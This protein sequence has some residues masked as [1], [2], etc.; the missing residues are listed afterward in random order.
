MPFRFPLFFIFL[1]FANAFADDTLKPIAPKPTLTK[2]YLSGDLS[3]INYHLGVLSEIERLQIRIDSVIATEWGS[4]A[5]ALWSAGWSPKQIGELVKSWDSLPPEP[6]KQKSA[7]WRKEWYVKHKE[8][9]SPVFEEIKE[10][11]R[12][13][14]ELFNLQVEESYWRSEIGLRI[15]F[16]E[17]SSTNSFPFPPLGD[18][19][20]EQG[21][22][23]I[24]S[25]PVALRD[26]GG[27]AE[28]RYQQKLHNSDSSLI[29][30]RPHSKPHP[31]SLFKA[32][33]QAVQ[34]KR[35]VL[36]Q[37]VQFSDAELYRESPV[38]A[39]R[40][41]YYPVFDS[42]PAEFQGHL[43][44]FWNKKDT[45]SLAVKNF[46]ANLQK[47]GFYQ[48][49]KLTLDTGALLQINT[50][51]SPILSL[52]LQ[53]IGGTLFGANISSSTNLRFVNQFGY[54][55]SFNAFYG[56][57]IRGG[58]IVS[59]FE[60]F[61][62]DDG[63]FFMEFKTLELEPINYFQKRIEREAR[64]LKENTGFGLDV[65]VKK[66]LGKALLTVATQIDR[67]E[68]TS[69]ASG[70]ASSTSICDVLLFPIEGFD[71]E[72]LEIE[73]PEPSYTYRAIT[74]SS[75]FPYAKWLWQ[76]E[77]YDRWFA[78][79]GF[80]AELMGGFKAVSVHSLEQSAPL[81]F[82][83]GGKIS[84]THPFSKYI[85]IM[86]GTE[87]GVNFRRTKMGDLV[88]PDELYG[89]LYGRSHP[90]PALDNRYRFA[91]GM[92]QSEEQWQTPANA[93][94]RYGLLLTGLSLHLNGNGL[95]LAAGYAKDGEPNPW[96]WDLGK[97]RFFAEPKIRIK[98]SAFDFIAGQS[99]SYFP[100]YF[101]EEG[102]EDV[103]RRFFLEFRG[104]F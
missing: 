80:M 46:L 65:G 78:T 25:T 100:D 31:D 6:A 47:D 45:G 38:P 27:T 43:E 56:Q 3:S 70:I 66:P 81:Y 24:L 91:M 72:D 75:M 48:N 49:V 73:E 22:R 93:S 82:S 40:F 64:I 20:E 54:N 28:Q 85:S 61:F 52:S 10:N 79:D 55:L 30:L 92:G 26:T 16:R 17:V 39:P 96:A 32:G 44:N 41:L 5:G 35:P 83:T 67:K 103:K 95:F 102:E 86:G 4:F 87:F 8:D 42:V 18:S 99:I 60:R 104:I 89:E 53:G 74:V 34:N 29:I 69:G 36:A 13:G 94:H 84:I 50:S 51:S 59:S 1:F 98:T 57:G 58:I 19:P 23:R 97:H 62:M 76:S 21:A 7:L 71:C 33:V 63:D 101:Y 90:D 37:N 68:I 11:P 15:P 2:L 12:L 14:E 77:G 88:F 9:G